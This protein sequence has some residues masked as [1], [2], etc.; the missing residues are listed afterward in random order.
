[1]QRAQSA[2]FSVL[3]LTV[4]N[5]TNN[6]SRPGKRPGEAARPVLN[7][8]RRAKKHPPTNVSIGRR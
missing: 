8:L 4:N 6:G 2:G 7:G 3:S 5:L 1:M